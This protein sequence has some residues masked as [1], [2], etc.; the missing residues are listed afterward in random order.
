MG[1]MRSPGCS[2][3]RDEGGVRMR[4]VRGSITIYL[5]MSLL[6][7]TGLVFTLTESARISCIQ[8]RLK[9]LMFLAADS[10]FAEYSREIFEDYGIMA[11]WKSDAEF[12][13]DFN[14]Y[15]E[16]N[17]SI[18]DTGLY[19]DADLWLARPAASAISQVQHLTDDQGNVFIEQ[20]CDYMEYF[21]VKE[22]LEGLLDILGVFD[23]SEKIGQ[24]VDKINSYKDIFLQVAES[25]SSIQ[26]HVDKARSVVNNP[27]VILGNMNQSMERY[28]QTG[29]N[30]YIARFNV[31][32]WNL[33]QGRDEVLWHMEGLLDDAQ[34]YEIYAG[35]AQEAVEN[36]RSELEKDKT[37]YSQETLDAISG[38]LD[39]LEL[40]SGDPDGAYYKITENAEAAAG[41]ADD[42]TSLDPLLS[43]LDPQDML[44]HMLDYQPMVS[45]YN[46]AFEGFDLNT[47]GVSNTMER[48]KR[49]KA[50]FLSTI[51]DIFTKGLLEAVAGKDISDNKADTSAFPS[52]TAGIGSSSGE[53]GSFA[54]APHK[55]LILAEYIA[56]HFGN[57][58]DQHEDSELLYEMEYILSGK[59]SDRDNLK[60]AVRELVLLRSGL[61]MIS[62]MRD[63]EKMQQAEALAL[64]IVGFTGIEPLIE[65]LK[66]LIMSVWCLAEGLCDVKALLQGNKVP[67]VKQGWQWTVTI[68]GLKNFNKS[69]VPAAT[70]EQ[71]MDY[72][73]Y[74]TVLLLKNSNAVLAFR[75]MD[76]IQANA[77]KNYQP[78]FRMKECINRASMTAAFDAKALFSSFLFVR[79]VGG[80]SGG[81]YGFT[82]EQEYSYTGFQ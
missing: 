55:R 45:Y 39:S 17:L 56:G 5:L 75:A 54:S 29:N 51:K 62:M 79:N 58:I 19:R 8:T 47:L 35:Q 26:Y 77:C 36:L 53:G 80:V 40:K 24:F 2:A 78:A 48:V 76:M 3:M 64:A 4:K 11:L 1:K 12:T 31:N 52:K 70:D 6:L 34:Q 46:A 42:L 67:L 21:L 65:S 30:T 41:F 22:A 73:G 9:S 44:E 60:V 32:Y 63:Q 28:A 66:T 27:K 72:A 33:G 50:G 68:T 61:N 43:E 13:A 20:V 59:A 16:H 74:L 38:Q 71:G 23:E 82:L 14:S 15:L 57:Y 18:A 10:C 7:V 25:V 37:A 81:M 49:E 69:V